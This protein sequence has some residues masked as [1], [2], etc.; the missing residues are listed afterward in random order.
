MYSLFCYIT[1]IFIIISFLVFSIL[2]IIY[3]YFFFFFFFLKFLLIIYW[4]LY[5]LIV[6]III[7]FPFPKLNYNNYFNYFHITFSP[8]SLIFF[9]SLIVIT[10]ANVYE[11]PTSRNLYVVYMYFKETSLISHASLESSNKESI[12]QS[13]NFRIF[14]S[15]TVIHCICQILDLVSCTVHVQFF[16]SSSAYHQTSDISCTK[17]QTL[18]VSR[19]VLQLS[20]CYPG[21][22]FSRPKPVFP[23]QNGINWDK[24]VFPSFSRPKLGKTVQNWEKLYGTIFQ[25]AKSFQKCVSNKNLTGQTRSSFHIIHNTVVMTYE[26]IIQISWNLSFWILHHK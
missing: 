17:S 14:T 4:I 22:G 18:N 8:H 12:N 24:P 11:C 7:L 25:A 23:V 26:L 21:L 1:I 15:L 20:L 13:I 2:F 16:F 19:L 10:H 5:L 9:P 3:I 6:I